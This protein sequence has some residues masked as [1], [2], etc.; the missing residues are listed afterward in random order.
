[1]QPFYSTDA[2]GII[3]TRDHVTHVQGNQ[4][5]EVAATVAGNGLL[6]RFSIGMSRT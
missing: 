4:E 6:F 1:M 3:F 5:K 2:C